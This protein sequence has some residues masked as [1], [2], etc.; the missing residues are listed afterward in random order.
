MILANQATGNEGQ[1]CT[2]SQIN[3]YI[4]N[5]FLR[6]YA[7]QRLCVKGEVSNCKYHSSGHI[8]FTI[9]DKASQL[10]CVM[11]S[12][13]RKNLGFRLQEGQSVIVQGNI[14]V[15][16]RDGK[17]QM[18]AVGITQEGAGQLYEEYEKLK[19]R[20][21]A[22]G[23]FDDSRKRQIP[24][25]AKKIGVVTAQTGA[26]IQDICNVSHRRNPYIQILLYPARVQGEGAHRTIIRGLQYFDT[27]DVDTVI[28]GR[29][30]GSMED[31]WEFNQEA[32]AYAIAETHKPVISA[33]GHETDTTIADFAADL[34]APTP[35]AAAELAVFS[36]REFEM[37]LKEFR[38]SLNWQMENILQ[39]KKMKLKQYETILGHASPKDMLAQKR[40][41][42]GEFAD[43]LQYIIEQ[44]LLSAKHQMELYIE[45]LKGLSPLY[46]LQ[47]GYS[48]V[49]DLDGNN[50]R[51]VQGLKEGQQVRL[52]MA[53]GKAVAEVREIA[54]E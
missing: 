34:R 27:T 49:S 13:Y 16:E 4:K 14:S 7:L 12:I 28:I 33:V 48:Y 50:I 36:W 42:L 44:K 21:L 19:K 11:F 26:V 39:L 35:S 51:S 43:Q 52:T 47:G 6:D 17:Y 23:L 24:K 53:D 41:E 37:G 3:L 30:G 40:M 9:K 8:Y 10:S 18:Y 22:E 5:M 38:Y 46:K 2:V 31:L 1:A 20:L 54:K 25:Y 29:G 32:L 15:Y 45:E